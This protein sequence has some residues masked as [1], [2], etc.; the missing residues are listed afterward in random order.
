MI[1]V[2]DEGSWTRPAL[3]PSALDREYFEAAGQGRL[4]VQACTSCDHRQFPPKLLCA[5]CGERPHW[6]DTAGT[7]TINTFTI[8]RRHGVEPFAS[9]APF[10]LAMIDLPEGVRLMGNVTGVDVDA[11]A[12]GDPVAAYA[13]R[14]DENLALPMWKPLSKATP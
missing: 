4:V 8:V 12:V 6:L 11:V 2:I 5:S 7:G 10:V 9:L 14:V 1:E 13:I 3:N